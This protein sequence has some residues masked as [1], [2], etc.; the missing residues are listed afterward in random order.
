[1]IFP[2]VCEG[3]FQDEH[4]FAIK[5]LE[6]RSERCMISEIAILSRL[7]G[8]PDISEFHQAIESNAIFPVCELAKGVSLFAQLTMPRLRRVICARLSALRL[9]HLNFLVHS[10]LKFDDVDILKDWAN[11]KRMDWRCATVVSIRYVGPCWLTTFT[12]S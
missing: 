12:I 1:M 3:I 2:P 5:I 7:R 9:P 11:V 10:D 6:R 8:H 4:P